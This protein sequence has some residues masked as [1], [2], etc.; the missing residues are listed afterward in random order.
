VTELAGMRAR[1]EVRTV[2]RMRLATLAWTGPGVALG[3]ALAGV[4]AFA[5]E[6]GIGPVGPL[7]V[8]F[9]EL[10]FR[11]GVDPDE[12]HVRADLCVPI[13]RE[14]EGRDGIRCVRSPRQ[15]CACLLFSGPPGPGLRAAHEVL[16]EWTAEHALLRDG[17]SV[18][19]AY[20]N[21]VG[22]D[23]TIELRL[24]LLGAP[25]SLIA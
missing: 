6:A 2:P 13:T 22:P 10:V 21:T 19:H 5:R 1:I 23:W 24:P 8:V 18:H 4:E 11:P 20:L 7:L 9:P 3:G 14:I 16:A 12:V 17:A 25:A 15:H